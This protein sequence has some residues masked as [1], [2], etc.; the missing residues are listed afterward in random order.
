MEPYIFIRE[1]LADEEEIKAAEMY[2]PIV[3]QRTAVPRNSLVIPRYS[4]LPFNKELED[5]VINLGSKLINSHIQHVYVADL[6]NWYQDIKE[7]T[8]YTWFKLHELPEEGPFILKGATNSKKYQFSTH[9]Y[10]DN[11]N[12]AMQ[13]FTNLIGD[14]YIGEQ[15]IYVR[16]YIPLKRLCDS[17][18][19]CPPI[20][21]EYRFFVLDGKIVGK[22]FYWSTYEDD[23][24][25]KVSP[26]F[27]PQDFLNTVINK[28]KLH[29]RFFVVDVARTAE[30]TWIVVELNDGCQSG[31]SC[32][33]P[34]DLYKNICKVLKRS[35]NES[36]ARK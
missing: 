34:Y 9:M 12:E 8:P 23:I 16:Q 18:G 27:V 28:I 32:I 25:Q 29:I 13:V 14:G 17:I 21:E 26:D 33:D 7:F 2:F 15:N 19:D 31:L 22:G 10:A 24:E 36:T 11:K 4:A 3:T 30:D 6:Q 35:K 5:D 20:S 1:S